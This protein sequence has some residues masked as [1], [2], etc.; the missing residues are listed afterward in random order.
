[1]GRHNRSSGT[2]SAAFRVIIILCMLFIFI[3]AFGDEDIQKSF[4]D[5]RHNEHE[6]A[7]E[8]VKKPSTLKMLKSTFALYTS[9]SPLSTSS[10][11]WGKLKAFLNQAQA[12][13]FPPNLHF[14]GSNNEA[15]AIKNPSGG[16]KVKEAVA[17]STERSKETVEQS[18]QTA[19]EIAGKT[20]QKMKEKIKKTFSHHEL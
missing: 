20:M 13:F 2:R 17:K 7:A 16:E 5:D 14:R 4:D 15:G 6:A 10:S 8:E 9:A 19:A 3:S 18:A 12:Y 11:Y 1:M